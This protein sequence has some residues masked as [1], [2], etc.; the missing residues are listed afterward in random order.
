MKPSRRYGTAARRTTDEERRARAPSV[1]PAA[2]GLGRRAAAPAGRGVRVPAGTGRAGWGSVAGEAVGGRAAILRAAEPDQELQ[3]R[4]ARRRH[5]QGGRAEPHRRPP[6]ASPHLRQP[7]AFPG[8]HLCKNAVAP[9]TTR[10][11]GRHSSLALTMLARRP[12]GGN[13]YTDPSLLEAAGANEALPTL[14]LP[15]L[16]YNARHWEP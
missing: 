10:T 15:T 14:L 12:S 1:D 5:P 3:P 7:P 16:S 6:R 13:V 11:A 9:R 2:G 4:P 8:G